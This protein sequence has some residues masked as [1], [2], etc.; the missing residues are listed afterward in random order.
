VVCWSAR[1]GSKVVL[2]RA[3]TGSALTTQGG[4]IKYELTFSGSP[5][6][7][8]NNRFIVAT[9]AEACHCGM[10]INGQ[11]LFTKVAT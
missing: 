5:R 10:P 11:E 8:Y 7:S 1:N 3:D 6:P 9:Y 2:V 4:S